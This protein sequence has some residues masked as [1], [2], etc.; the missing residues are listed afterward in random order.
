MKKVANSARR[1]GQTNAYW[2]HRDSDSVDYLFTDD[3]RAE[4]RERAGENAEDLPGLSIDWW[5]IGITSFCLFVGF[6]IGLLTK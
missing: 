6:I 4:A 3:Q 2:H 1:F 5:M